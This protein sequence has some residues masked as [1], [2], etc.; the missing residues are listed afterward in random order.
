MNDNDTSR[1]K[2]F[3]ERVITAAK[4]GRPREMITVGLCYA[5][6]LGVKKEVEL[7][8]FWF[9]KVM[10]NGDPEAL[11]DLGE[12]YRNGSLIERDAEKAK[13][14]FDT[15]RSIY[16][17]FGYYMLGRYYFL[18]SEINSNIMAA[19]FF[20]KSSKFGHVISKMYYNKLARQGCV[21]RL[22]QIFAYMQYPLVVVC[23][24]TSVYSGNSYVKLWRY[25]DLISSK[26]FHHLIIK[27]W[28]SRGIVEEGYSENNIF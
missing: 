22:N 25:N 17:L 3:F 27:Q 23:C 13:I 14:I 28:L 12:L 18:S 16:P 9:N 1:R 5:N 24:C 21:G 11:S 8:K 2:K 10:E 4:S 26:K 7:S 19:D 20:K 6:G 15:L